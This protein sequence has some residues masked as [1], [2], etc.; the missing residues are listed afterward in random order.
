MENNRKAWQGKISHL[1]MKQHPEPEAQSYWV[2]IWENVLFLHSLSSFSSTP[3]SGLWLD[4]N[5]EKFNLGFPRWDQELHLLCSSVICPTFMVYTGC[6]SFI[7]LKYRHLP[8]G[9][10]TPKCPL[11]WSE[12][13]SSWQFKRAKIQM[14]FWRSLILRWL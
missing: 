4:I 5:L 1:T 13:S 10:S 8:M 6:P 9:C 3:S 12:N 7:P 2:N 11:L 14:T